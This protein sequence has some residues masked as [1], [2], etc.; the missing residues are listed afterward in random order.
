[1]TITKQTNGTYIID[2]PTA[3][4]T[5]YNTSTVVK[6]DSATVGLSLPFTVT[7]IEGVRDVYLELTGASGTYKERRCF[8]VDDNLECQ[9]LTHLSELDTDARLLDNTVYQYFL[10]KESMSQV[11][12]GCACICATTKTIYDDLKLSLDKSC[13]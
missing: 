8:L 1:M 9:V 10:I 11:G 12:D 13:C 4:K 5:T 2:L 7:F 6:V 3:T